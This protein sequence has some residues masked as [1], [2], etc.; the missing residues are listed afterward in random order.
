MVCSE[1]EIVRKKAKKELRK[2]PFLKDHAKFKVMSVSTDP[3]I[4]GTLEQLA[5]DTARGKSMPALKRAKE[6]LID[7]TK[8]LHHMGT[9]IWVDHGSSLRPATAF[10]T[11]LHGRTFLMTVDHAFVTPA[12]PAQMTTDSP[13]R[14]L[15]IHVD[16]DSES[17]SESEDEDELNVAITSIGSQSPDTWSH[18]G[19]HSGSSSASV[20]YSGGSTPAIYEQYQVDQATTALDLDDISS[21]LAPFFS[22]PKTYLPKQIAQPSKEKLVSLGKLV[23]W[24]TDKD[25]AL[26][27][28]TNEEM[29]PKLE[30][31]IAEDQLPAESL[32]GPKSDAPVVA[33][34]SS[35]GILTGTFT[36]IPLCTRLPN[37]SSF[38]DV[39]RIRL[40]GPLANGDCGSPVKNAGTGELYGHIIAGCRSTGTAYIM[41]AHQIEADFPDLELGPGVE[42]LSAR[43]SKSNAIQPLQIQFSERKERSQKGPGLPQLLKYPEDRELSPVENSGSMTSTPQVVVHMP[44]EA[45]PDATRRS[46]DSPASPSDKLLNK[47]TC[48]DFRNDTIEPNSSMDEASI[49]R[50]TEAGTFAGLDVRFLYWTQKLFSFLLPLLVLG[51]KLI[52]GDATIITLH[53]TL[54]Y[55]GLLLAPSIISVRLWTFLNVVFDSTRIAIIT[56]ICLSCDSIILVDEPVTLIFALSEKWAIWNGCE[57]S[58]VLVG[59]DNPRLTPI[60]IAISGLLGFALVWG[61]GRLVQMFHL[62]LGTVTVI[63]IVW[64][65]TVLYFSL[66]RR[67]RWE[68]SQVSGLSFQIAT[69]AVAMPWITAAW[70]TL[71]AWAPITRQLWMPSDIAWMLMSTAFILLMIPGIGYVQ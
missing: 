56:A 9:E 60:Q 36:G 12:S 28:I 2:S 5:S 22:L 4:R 48:G 53:S 65:I 59:K 71:C 13:P 57:V 51:F 61:I 24:S 69:A 38:Q 31:S 35:S 21:R 10:A 47:K 27:E 20:S 40:N 1:D 19:S 6:V 70:N 62:S 37:S 41:A 32:P 50:K 34:T 33:Y 58:S 14:K 45:I 17:D 39:Y 15:P 55:Y 11:Q 29:I 49:Q 43:S 44:Y 7:S 67:K 63:E 54:I 52:R 26:I 68:P 66:K 3:S 25:W 46:M 42:S 8:P 30:Q 16:S 18:S 64:P 23:L